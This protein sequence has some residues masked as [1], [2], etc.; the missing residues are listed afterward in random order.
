MT[1]AP[2]SARCMAQSA[3]HHLRH[4]EHHETGQRVH[5]RLTRIMPE[6][7]FSVEPPLAF[8]TFNRPARATP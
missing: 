5:G 6:V 1:S 7:L 4:V 2:R 3:R 8:L